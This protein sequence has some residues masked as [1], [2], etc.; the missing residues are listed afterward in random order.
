LEFRAGNNLKPTETGFSACL[1]GYY[2]AGLISLV[3]LEKI[4][5]HKVIKNVD[6]EI[7]R[8]VLIKFQP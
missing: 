8:A 2:G 6:E 5:K 4:G 3:I 1:L 7:I